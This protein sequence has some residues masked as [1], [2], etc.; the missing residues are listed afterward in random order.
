MPSA[1]VTSTTPFDQLPE[2]LSVSEFQAVARL[3]RATA[4][5]VARQL[6]D[7]VRFG[8]TVRVPKS[9]LIRG[10]VAPDAR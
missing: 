1:S 2:L 10:F 8:R 7:V 6:P 5:D 9:V 4:Y 3:S